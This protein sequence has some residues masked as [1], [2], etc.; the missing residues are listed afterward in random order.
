MQGQI[1]S[2]AQALAY[3]L[4]DRE[5]SLHEA[6]RE[7]HQELGL[8][9]K[10]DLYVVKKP[11]ERDIFRL[12]D[13]LENIRFLGDFTSQLTGTLTGERNLAENIGLYFLLPR[14]LPQIP[15]SL[16]NSAR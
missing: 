4:A 14:A 6:A 13:R 15:S 12:L 5:G 3:G 9:E 11:R 10:L 1:F 16:L 8:S 7:I 2:G